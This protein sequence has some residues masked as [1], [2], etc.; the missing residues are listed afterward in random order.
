[1]SIGE[2]IEELESHLSSLIDHYNDGD[3]SKSLEIKETYEM[4]QIL[5]YKKTKDSRGLLI[6][7][8]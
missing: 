3:L 4:I 1:M 5:T 7:P 6:G 2:K 8:R